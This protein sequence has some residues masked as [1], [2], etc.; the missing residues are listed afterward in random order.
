MTDEVLPPTQRNERMKLSGIVGMFARIALPGFLAATS[1]AARAEQGG[2]Y[3]PG[4]FAWF[5][6]VT[7][8]LAAARRFYGAVFGWQF[9]TVGQ[10]PES[11]TFAV[12]E[13]ARIGGMLQRPAP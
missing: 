8:D 7:D 5:D 3:H 6:L 9:L 11:Y 12:L 1:L 4:K 2:Q 10:K 13:G